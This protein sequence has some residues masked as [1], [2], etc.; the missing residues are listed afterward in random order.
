MDVEIK[1]IEE[2]TDETLFAQRVADTMKEL[3]TPDVKF[4]VAYNPGRGY[5]YSAMIIKITREN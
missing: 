3:N 1:M 5:L 4:A 2:H